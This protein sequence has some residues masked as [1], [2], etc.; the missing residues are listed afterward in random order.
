LFSAKIQENI[1]EPT[2]YHQVSIIAGKANKVTVI[3][4]EL[5]IYIKSFPPYLSTIISLKIQ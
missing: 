3:N 2:S 4:I 1:A 5:L